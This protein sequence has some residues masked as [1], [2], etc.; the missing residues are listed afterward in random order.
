MS[1]S[2]EWYVKYLEQSRRISELQAALAEV[3]VG[4]EELAADN[5]EAMACARRAR[6]ILLN[7][8]LDG[9]PSTA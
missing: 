9:G 7:L 4:L 8:S 1:N 2:D 3:I 6:Q 5:P